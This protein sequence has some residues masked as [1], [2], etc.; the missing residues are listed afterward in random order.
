MDRLSLQKK[1][2]RFSQPY[3][4]LGPEGGGKL[5]EKV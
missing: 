1:D 4:N 3:F 5:E 2:Q